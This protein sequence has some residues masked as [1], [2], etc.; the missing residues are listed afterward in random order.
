MTDYN[1]G[2]N[3]N[4]NIF[5]GVTPYTS[6]REITFSKEVYKGHDIL[7]VQGLN[8]CG[9]RIPLDWGLDSIQLQKLSYLSSDLFTQLGCQF[10]DWRGTTRCSATR[11]DIDG[12]LMDYQFPVWGICSVRLKW[13]LDL[14]P[15]YGSVK[16]ITRDRIIRDI[17]LNLK[18]IRSLFEHNHL[19]QLETDYRVKQNDP[20]VE[21]E[22]LN[23]L[24][25]DIDKAWTKYYQHNRDVMKELNKQID[26]DTPKLHEHK[27]QTM[28]L[29]DIHKIMRG[30][31]E[32]TD[33]INY[34]GKDDL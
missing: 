20:M 7:L 11:Y 15:D 26:R 31:F 19:L 9:F 27:H 13:V 16:G 12:I 30:E 33:Q 34:K 4:S 29:T 1:L 10:C 21:P 32:G 17:H 5:T 24:R 22:T 3:D 28:S 8:N 18:S 2:D 23:R 6:D 25:R 14:V